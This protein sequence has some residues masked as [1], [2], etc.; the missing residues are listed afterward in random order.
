V[1]ETPVTEVTVNEAAGPAVV[2]DAVDEQLVRQLTE[3]HFWHLRS[4]STLKR[5]PKSH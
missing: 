4:F 1:K 3:R 5:L 2:G